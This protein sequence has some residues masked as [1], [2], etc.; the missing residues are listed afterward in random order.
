[1]KKLEKLD[2][3]IVIIICICMIISV[4]SCYFIIFR[5]ETKPEVEVEKTT[6]SLIIS[7]VN[8]T[9]KRTITF[10]NLTTTTTNATVLGLLTKASNVGNFLFETIYDSQNDSIFVDLIDSSRNDNDTYWKCYINGILTSIGINK[11][12]IKNNDLI[13]MKFE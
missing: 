13:E 9:G 7:F 8:E 6:V 4:F 2:K 5:E 1:M 10:T 12:Q 11:Q 3:I